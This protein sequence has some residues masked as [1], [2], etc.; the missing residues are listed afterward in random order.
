MPEKVGDSP[1][2]SNEKIVHVLSTQY[3]GLEVSFFL[4]GGGGDVRKTQIDGAEFQTLPLA[5]GCRLMQS[6]TCQFRVM[7]IFSIEGNVVLFRGPYF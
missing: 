3:L 7:L 4:V 2:S 5:R 6:N 1:F